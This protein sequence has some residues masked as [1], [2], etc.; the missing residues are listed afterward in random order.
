MINYDKQIRISKDAHKKLKTAA[1]MCDMSIGEFIDQ[2]LQFRIDIKEAI[3]SGGGLCSI[4][5][6]SANVVD[7]EYQLL[8]SAKE[9]NC[10]TPQDDYPAVVTSWAIDNIAKYSK[11]INNVIEKHGKILL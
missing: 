7:I 4:A 11:V 2:L 8:E 3:L 5:N 1:A 10:D 6:I 9:F